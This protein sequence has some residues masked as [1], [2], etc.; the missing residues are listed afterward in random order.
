[1][2]EFHRLETWLDVQNS[3]GKAVSFGAQDSL[4]SSLSRLRQLWRVSCQIQSLPE[5]LHVDI[6]RD[7]S[8]A[9]TVRK[10]VARGG[11]SVKVLVLQSRDCTRDHACLM[12]M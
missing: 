3:E 2:H 9:S 6:P 12:H 7:C 4:L 5:H 1:M 10:A 11:R 8:L